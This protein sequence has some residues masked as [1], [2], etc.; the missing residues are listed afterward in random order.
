PTAVADGYL[1]DGRGFDLAKV[2]GWYTQEWYQNHDINEGSTTVR[3]AM[4]QGF[5]ERV[6]DKPDR[7]GKL[8]AR[9]VGN[10]KGLV[11]QAPIFTDAELAEADQVFVTEGIFDAISWI[12]AGRVAVSNISSSNFPSDLLERIKKA[13]PANKKLPTIVWAQDGDKAGRDAT[14]KHVERAD[15]LGFKSAAAQPTTA[16]RDWN[17]LHQLGRMTDKDIEE[18]LHQ[19]DL[20]LAKSPADKA[21]LM[22]HKRE[23]RQF[24]FTFGHKLYWWELNMDAYDRE[25]GRDVDASALTAEER[26]RALSNA[27]VV[28]CIATAIPRPLYFQANTQTDESWYYFRIETADGIYKAPF[29]PK[30]LTGASEFKNRLLAIKNAWYTGSAKQLDR[31]MQ[32]MMHNLKTVETTDFIG[33]SKEHKAWI[34]NEVAIREGRARKINS[35]DYYEFGKLSVKSL[36]S[37]PRID[38]NLN[39]RE[40]DRNWA[41]HVIGAFG[42]AGT[43]TTAFFL[44]S[45]FAEQIRGLTKSFPFFELVGQAGAGKSTLIEFLWKC[46]GREDYEGFDPQKATTA[47]RARMFSQVSNLPVVLIES[48]REATEGAKAKQFD[49]DDLKTAY[50]G[51]AMRSRGVKTGGNETYD[52]PFR[53]S[54]VISQNDQVAASEAILS[55]IVHITVTREHQTPETKRHAEWL[56]RCPI[57]SVSGFLAEAAIKEKQIME[58]FQQSTVK[59]EQTLLA[60]SK[61]RMIRIAKNHA[62]MMALVECLGP[63]C[64]NLI[65]DHDVEDALANLVYMAEA[66]Q[67]AI[68]ADHPVVQEFWEAVDYIESS[69]ADPL[70][71][72]YGK[73][74]MGFA[75]NVKEFERWCGEFKLRVPESR[76]LKQHLKGSKSRKFVTSNHPVRSKISA[77]KTVKCWIFEAPK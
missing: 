62:Q 9:A 23:R 43:I 26:D 34:F 44:G 47:A 46:L 60:N 45:L 7:F 72:H 1:R 35:E 28:N 22:Y 38:I 4:P 71:N 70:I 21:L 20:L 10:Y 13:C 37:E 32:D 41:Q 16:K 51:R 3:F 31:L 73:P 69:R 19:G 8:K 5:W 15:R 50:N 76:I 11:W 57:E 2:K 49:W 56:E 65:E 30:Q 27:G 18:Y 25:V 36:A 52:P 42:S 67:Q 61:V 40:Y 17:D 24:W 63:L 53:G 55:R 58:L 29:T 77:D 64:L 39:T 14:L 68:N 75:I 33:Y 6:L 59:H 54:I 48:D 74:E 12:H 66:R